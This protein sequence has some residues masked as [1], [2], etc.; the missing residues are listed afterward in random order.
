MSEG[1]WVRP[2]DGEVRLLSV[3]TKRG[4]VVEI[5]GP[6]DTDIKELNHGLAGMLNDLDLATLPGRFRLVVVGPTCP[7]CDCPVPHAVGG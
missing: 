1:K 3:V 4:A 7:G 6:P 5:H 2:A